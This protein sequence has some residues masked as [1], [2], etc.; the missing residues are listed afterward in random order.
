MRRPYLEE[1]R[2]DIWPA[3]EEFIRLHPVGL[4]SNE[5]KGILDRNLVGVVGIVEEQALQATTQI[6]EGVVARW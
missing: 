1:P 5:V 2:L 6:H 4:E 3:A